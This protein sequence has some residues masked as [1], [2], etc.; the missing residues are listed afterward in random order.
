[1]GRRINAP[2]SS[3]STTDISLTTVSG[4]TKASIKPPRLAHA[5]NSCASCLRMVSPGARG[6]LRVDFDLFL[7]NGLNT[8]VHSSHSCF[9]LILILKRA[10]SSTEIRQSTPAQ[11]NLAA[12][13]ILSD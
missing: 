7:R 8:I 11:T 2:V 3:T 13:W 10:A 12:H 5:L 9:L 4:S 6:G 1:M